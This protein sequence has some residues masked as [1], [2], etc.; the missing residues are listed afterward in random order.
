MW[1]APLDASRAADLGA[2]FRGIAARVEGG[3]PLR[4]AGL[5]TPAGPLR[6]CQLFEI[7]PADPSRPEVVRV[8]IRGNAL[9]DDGIRDG[10]CLVLDARVRLRDGQT[11]L[12]DVGGATMLRR[13][14][15]GGLEATSGDVLPL[16]RAADVRIHGAVVGILRK[17]G[18]GGAPIR[19]AAGT[20]AA[21]RVTRP[22]V[23]PLGRMDEHRVRR[24]CRLEQSL[25]AVTATYA[26]TEH[27][28]LREALR[29]EAAKLRR[30]I[31]RERARIT[32]A[33]LATR[34]ESA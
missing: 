15:G 26:T 20:P 34:S 28:R 19:A 6:R 4:V 13:V 2:S 23:S 31:D 29:D 7:P 5:L 9:V 21:G 30:E 33:A 10:D 18:F 22:P 16:V 17:R 14:C 12:A 25:R 27:P 8:R 32:W 1:K 24:L 3:R 11:V